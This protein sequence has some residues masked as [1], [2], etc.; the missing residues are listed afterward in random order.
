M[1][2]KIYKIETPFRPAIVKIDDKGNYIAIDES[3]ELNC[4]G[5]IERDKVEKD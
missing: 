1:K 2:E 5:N 3:G 4:I